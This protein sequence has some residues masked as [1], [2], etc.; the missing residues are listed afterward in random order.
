M[1]RRRKRDIVIELTAL[2][3]VI[4]IMIFMVMNE[5]SKLIKEKQDMLETARQENIEQAGEIDHLS[6]QLAEAL[7]KLDE[8]DLEEILDRLQHA[9]SMLAGYQAVDD[10]VVVL[11]IN[12]E[13]RYHNTVRYLTF[14][15]SSDL[16]EEPPP[17]ENRSDE[18]FNTALNKLRVFISEYAQ[19]AVDDN[20]D[21]VMVCVIFSYDPDKVFQ[22]DFDAVNRVL[23][24]AEAKV[25]RANFRYRLNP[26]P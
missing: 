14:G 19:K 23:E 13:N 12:L 6:A 2:L 10:V 7:G 17:I 5:N 15:A 22:R 24:N 20:S 4:M 21:S 18:E 25:N 16:N 3:D 11:N 26:L 1:R 9:E 8:G